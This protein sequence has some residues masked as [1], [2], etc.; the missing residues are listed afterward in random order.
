MR[1]QDNVVPIAGDTG[2]AAFA[3]LLKRFRV[4]AGLSQQ[5]LADRALVSVQAIS[6]LERGYR[7]AP[8]RHTIDRLVTALELDDRSRAE[9]EEA[10]AQ[11]RERG[12]LPSH[13]LASRTDNLP[14]RLTSFFGGPAVID[15]VVSLLADTSLVTIAG[16]GGAGKTRAAVE[17]GA[18][19]IPAF[20]QGVWFV[21]LAPL[22]NDGLV[23]TAIAGAVGFQEPTKQPPLEALLG[24]LEQKHL[25]L[26]LD[27]CEHLIADVRRTVALLLQRCPRV[28]VLATSREPLTIAGESVYRIPPLAFPED[29]PATVSD[30]LGYGAVALFADRAAH[31]DGRF[32]LTAANATD[33]ALI[34]RRL[35]GL[36]LAIELAAARVPVLSPRQLVRRLDQVFTVL[37]RGDQ[38]ILPRHQTMRTAIDWSYDLLS[39]QAQV[40]FERLAIFSGGF[41]LDAAAAVCQGD[42]IDERDVLDLLASLVDKSLLVVEFSEDEARY[43]F[44]DS[45][46]QYALER[47]EA[48]GDANALA[49]RHARAYLALAE[50]LDVDWYVAPERSWL[51]LANADFDNFRAALDWS[52]GARKD[53]LTGQRLAAALARVWYAL[54]VV[55]G[56]LGSGARSRPWTL[57]PPR[58]SPDGC[59]SR[60]ANCTAPSA[61]IA[62]RWRRARRPSRR[63]TGPRI[64]FRSLRRDRPS[65]RP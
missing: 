52:L 5:T 1:S 33:I 53:L 16:T 48:G 62:R 61:N 55:E 49:T 7:K 27:N 6:A 64:R 25:L 29:A 43:R 17:A 50:Q 41:S 22:R 3:S 56:R 30:A 36:P 40:L 38:A 9:F 58:R 39:A 10:A 13:R 12:P 14:R 63:S 19:L 21:D 65:G 18:T 60:K 24:Y 8:Y 20:P 47:L 51:A 32:A 23:T 2:Q 57:R 42:G 28:G 44:L 45:T 46:Q 15:K 54:S 26:I 35:D 4:A 34:C 59:S 37:T 11:A 31:A